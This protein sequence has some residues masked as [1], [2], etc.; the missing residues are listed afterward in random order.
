MVAITAAEAALNRQ[1]QSHDGTQSAESTLCTI[2]GFL[3]DARVGAATWAKAR[4]MIQERQNALAE[5]ASGRT[6]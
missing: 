2:W 1:L 5:R 4:K 6:E 3:D